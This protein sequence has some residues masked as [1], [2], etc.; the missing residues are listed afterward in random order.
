[1]PISAIPLQ[2][3]T[4]FRDSPPMTPRT[5]V[6]T[7]PNSRHE[8]THPNPRQP[9]APSS[10]FIDGHEHLLVL[11][12]DGV[13][14]Y[15]KITENDRV[16]R[17]FDMEPFLPK[18]INQDSNADVCSICLEDIKVGD[19]VTPLKCKHSFHCACICKW[20][21]SRVRQG[22]AGCCPN[23]NHQVCSP[24]FETDPT[25]DSVNSG[26]HRYLPL[27]PLPTS[28]EPQNSA[29]T[30]STG[31]EPVLPAPS[32]VRRSPHLPT[33]EPGASPSTTQRRASSMEMLQTP[34]KSFM[35]RLSFPLLRTFRSA[36]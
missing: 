15:Q 20:L 23:C 26:V 2:M 16:M 11:G 34:K 17:G 31:R 9:H 4:L 19:V 25:S 5:R 1:M 13:L 12:A 7:P 28:A 6:P 30:R 33:I 22:F 27:P 3:S 24:I 35:A 18:S 29:T 8:S 14:R 21:S 32:T 10:V 36:H